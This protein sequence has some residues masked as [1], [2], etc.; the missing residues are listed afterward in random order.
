MQKKLIY[1]FIS[2]ILKY[3]KIIIELSKSINIPIKDGRDISIELNDI[4]PDYHRK[5]M[6]GKIMKLLLKTLY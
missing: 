2:V 5:I 6:Y 4:D 1:L 3:E